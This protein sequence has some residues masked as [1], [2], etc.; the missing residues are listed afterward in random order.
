MKK[1]GAENNPVLICQKLTAVLMKKHRCLTVILKIQNTHVLKSNA[2]NKAMAKS[3]GG[4]KAA[5]V[6]LICAMSCFSH[7]VQFS[8]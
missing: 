2:S 3:A 7:L 5:A 4:V 1:G 8:F 6:N